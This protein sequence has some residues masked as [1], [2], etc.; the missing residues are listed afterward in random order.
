M[1]QIRARKMIERLEKHH[2]ELRLQP[3][4]LLNS[5]T[6]ASPCFVSDKRT[7]ISFILSLP[8]PHLHPR[9]SWVMGSETPLPAIASSQ[10]HILFVRSL[11]SAESALT[12]LRISCI[13]VQLT[14]SLIL[15]SRLLSVGLHQADTRIHFCTPPF[16][17]D[18]DLA[19]RETEDSGLAELKHSLVNAQSVRPPDNNQY[20][21]NKNQ[22]WLMVKPFFL[23]KVCFLC[24]TLSDHQQHQQ[25]INLLKISQETL[26]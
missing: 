4:L 3:L 10:Y 6:Y 26:S 1:S 20:R 5:L 7:F 8:L 21:I 13:S 14:S 11:G 12:T 22:W 18:D 2:T 25:T 17:A 15:S 23:L 19:L 24:G 9:L 16:P